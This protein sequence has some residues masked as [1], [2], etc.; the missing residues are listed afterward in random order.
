MTETER[1]TELP[2]WTPLGVQMRVFQERRS[3]IEGGRVEEP[4][5]VEPPGSASS[6]TTDHEIGSLEPPVGLDLGV[7]MVDMTLRFVPRTDACP[8]CAGGLIEEGGSCGLC[9]YDVQAIMARSV[10]HL[11]LMESSEVAQPRRILRALDRARFARKPL[12]RVAHGLERG[13]IARSMGW[14]LMERGDLLDWVIG[15]VLTDEV[16][17]ASEF[18][19]R[20]PFLR[21]TSDWNAHNEAVTWVAVAPFGTM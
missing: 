3:A 18:A 2:D 13:Q 12:V 5:S 9:D 19:D 16:E 4:L 14:L 15:E 8:D 1:I 6:R 10:L 7:G 20:F 21:W 17:V 11:N